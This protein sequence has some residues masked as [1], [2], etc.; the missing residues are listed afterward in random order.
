MFR[1]VCVFDLR[2]AYMVVRF[3]FIPFNKSNI[4]KYLIGSVFFNTI[5]YVN[6]CPSY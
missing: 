3:F 6:F 5:F 2:T 1:V 4:T